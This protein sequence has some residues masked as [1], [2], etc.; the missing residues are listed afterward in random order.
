MAGEVLQI[1]EREESRFDEGLKEAIR[2][3]IAGKEDCPECDKE[4]HYGETAF[5]A[6]S[7]EKAG[8]GCVHLVLGSARCGTLLHGQ[9]HDGFL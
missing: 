6:V 5:F 1:S 7:V 2:F 3:G 4:K 8:Y 9:G